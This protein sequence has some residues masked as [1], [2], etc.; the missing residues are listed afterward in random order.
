M[1]VDFVTSKG[2]KS[3]VLDDLET[4][5]NVYAH[6]YFLVHPETYLR[7]WNPTEPQLSEIFTVGGKD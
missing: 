5:G 1:R 2:E 6:I 7:D 4:R 3:G